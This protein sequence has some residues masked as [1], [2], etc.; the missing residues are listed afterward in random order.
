[1]I[2]AYTVKGYGLAT[3]GHPQNHSSLLTETQMRALATGLGTDLDDPWAPLPAGPAADLCAAT[4]TRLRRSPATPAAA[5]VIP[6]D[7]D[8]TPTGT[9]HTQQALGRALLDLTRKI[10]ADG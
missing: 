4:A 3:Q 10:N 5:P 7:L 6:E 9:G 1:M 8:R 2:F